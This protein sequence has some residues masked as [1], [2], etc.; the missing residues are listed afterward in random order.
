MKGPRFDPWQGPHRGGSDPRRAEGWLE[1]TPLVQPLNPHHRPSR[2][3]KGSFQT[4]KKRVVSGSKDLFVSLNVKPLNSG[5]ADTLS[6]EL[7]TALRDSGG[8]CAPAGHRSAPHR[9]P[10]GIRH[11]RILATANPP[12]LK[13]SFLVLQFRVQQDDSLGLREIMYYYYFSPKAELKLF[14]KSWWGNSKE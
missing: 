1:P 5:N 2:S 3:I 7:S 4:K 8:P 6:W 13:P 10:S 9:P 12:V 11:P 14:L